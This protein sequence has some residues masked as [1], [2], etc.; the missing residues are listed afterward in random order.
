MAGRSKDILM[1]A[2]S[3]LFLFGCLNLIRYGIVSYNLQFANNL[4]DSLST[5]SLTHSFAVV[6]VSIVGLLHALFF[7]MECFFWDVMGRR[8]MRR[9]TQEQIEFTRPMAMS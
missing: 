7:V 8:F 6:C 5:S 1:Q 4:F 2:W 9:I 3:A